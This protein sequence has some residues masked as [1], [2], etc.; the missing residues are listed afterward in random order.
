[1]RSRLK[2]T[3]VPQLALQRAQEV[4]YVLNLRWVEHSEVADHGIGLRAAI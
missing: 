2:L 4:Q 1:M 3:V